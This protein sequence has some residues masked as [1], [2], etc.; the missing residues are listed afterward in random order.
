MKNEIESKAL[1]RACGIATT[2]PVLAT[3]AAEARRAAAAL[4]AP[5]VLKVVSPDIVHKA[6]AGGVRV[7]VPLAEVERAFDAIVS[8]CHASSPNARIEGVLVEERV[9]EGLEVFIGARVDRDYGAIVLLGHGGTGVEQR[10]APAAALAP[11]DSR[12]AQALIDEAF[13]PQRQ[14]LDTDGRAALLKCLLAIAGGDGLLMRGETG[15]L[16][17]NPVVVGANGCVAVDAVVMPLDPALSARVLSDEQVARAGNARRARLGDGRALFDPESI[18]FIGASTVSSKLG[19]RSIRNLLDYGFEG[20][21]YPIHPKAATICDL[22]AYP[23]I[24]DVPG[25]VDRAYIALGAAQ[26][27][28]ALRECQ[29]KGVKVVQVLT[30]GFSEWSAAEDAATG[31]RLEREIAGVLADGGMRMVGPNCIGTFS[32]TS[33]MALGAA[34]YCPTEKRGITFISQSGTFAGDVVRRAQVQ[35]VPVARVLSCGNCADLDLIDF[36]LFC[37][38]DPDTTLIGFYS[39]SI[40]DPGLF[41]RLARRIRKPVVLFKGGTT[42]Q[43]LAA[44][45][46]HTAALAT[47][48]TLWRAA[49]RQAGVLQVDSV[50][51]LMDAFLIHSAHGSLPGPRLG[52]F[53]SGGGVSVTCSDVAARA[54]LQVPAFST[55]NAGKLRRFGVPGTSIANPIDIPVWGLK[56]GE[57]HIFGE[58]IDQLKQDPALDVV[59]VYVEMGSIMDFSDDEASGLKELESICA[60]IAS[61]KPT[62]PKVVVALRSTGDQT[63]EDFVRRKRAELLPKGIAVFSSTTRAVRALQKLFTLSARSD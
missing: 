60:S 58:I 3:T 27:P 7:G 21:I 9:P 62:G 25:P 34:R 1:L 35:G 46:S 24:S 63:Q 2:E 37:E 50:D 38:S 40:R 17:I 11:L 31:E 23:T 20:R 10:E 52:V 51:E 13:A 28:Q 59:V 26:V 8:A 43:G 22:P 18:A 19:Y 33:R 45:G 14:A 30:A 5:A 53:G 47:D 4:S 55:A 36:L 54:G 6:A 16:D 56:D 12:A 57:R 49:L 61:A 15:D 48:Q 44:A 29:R 42:E 39:E 41:F 32:A